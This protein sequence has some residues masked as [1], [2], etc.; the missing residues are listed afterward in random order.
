MRRSVLAFALLACGS[1]DVDWN[2]KDAFRECA[3]V[4]D[5]W[6][7]GDATPPCEALHMCANEAKLT[8]DQGKQLDLMIA[9]GKCA[10]L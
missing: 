9:A 8:V 5:R 7:A 3:A 4:I 6:R 10:P 1:R 2:R